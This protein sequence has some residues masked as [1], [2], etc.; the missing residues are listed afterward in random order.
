VSTGLSTK[1]ESWRREI[2][3]A[4][5][6]DRRVRD[7]LVAQNMGLVYMVVRR[8]RNRGAD[9]EEL[10]QI[11]AIGL[12]KA[13]DHFDVTLPYTFSTYAVPRIIGEIR[14]FLRDD[15]MIHISRSVK[16]N[17]RK[18]A[19]IREQ[20]QKLENREPTMGELQQQTGLSQEELLLA[21]EALQG[22]DSL[23][24][25]IR[26]EEGK[27]QTMEEHLEA[28][29]HFEGALLDRLAVRQELGE[30]DESEQNLIRLRYMQGCTQT[31]AARRLGTNQVAVSRMERRILEK[32]RRKLE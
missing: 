32:L 25:P 18:V 4:Q 16:Q 11:G 7:Q 29:E 8:F 1:E 26:P 12:I 13:I 9:E 31:E 17:A 21:L 10:S 5:Q 28:P 30:L 15:G 20:Q 24:K 19:M 22:V 2:T 27:G 23:A 6:G 14:R 3:Q